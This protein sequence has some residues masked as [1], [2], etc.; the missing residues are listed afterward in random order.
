MGAH[1]R[2]KKP[3]KSDE[4][5]ISLRKFE[6]ALARVPACADERPGAPYLPEEVI[7]L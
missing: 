4:V 5:I 6:R 1:I 3:T 2:D 7:G